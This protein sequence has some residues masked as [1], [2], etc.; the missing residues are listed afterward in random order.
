MIDLS[1]GLQGLQTGNQLG[2]GECSKEERQAE[3]SSSKKYILKKI[4]KYICVNDFREGKGEC[5]RGRYSSSDES[6]GSDVSCTP[7]TGDGMGNWVHGC[8]LNH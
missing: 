6:H 1:Q 7:P 5:E 2:N 3:G 4:K 8:T